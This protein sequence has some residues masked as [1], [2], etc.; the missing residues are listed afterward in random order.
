VYQERPVDVKGLTREQMLIDALGEWRDG[1]VSGP[2]RN[3]A[4]AGGRWHRVLA[5]PR[6]AGN[7]SRGSGTRGAGGRRDCAGRER[8]AGPAGGVCAGPGD[9]AR[10]PGH[11]RGGGGGERGRGGLGRDFAGDGL[12]GDGTEADRY[13]DGNGQFTE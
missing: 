10:D 4:C 11:G 8:T 12:T 13:A 6:P 2:V 5:C 3:R 9:G 7:S 1:K